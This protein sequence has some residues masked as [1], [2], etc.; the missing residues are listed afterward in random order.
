MG[1]E[2]VLRPGPLPE[3]L[4]CSP[5]ACGGDPRPQQEGTL[6]RAQA[7]GRQRKASLLTLDG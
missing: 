7:S 2:Y 3:L 1:A 6:S 5:P 4:A